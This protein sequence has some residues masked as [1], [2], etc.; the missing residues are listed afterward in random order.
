MQDKR[1]GRG[2]NPH[3]QGPEHFAG[4]S[5]G[6]EKGGAYD[7]EMLIRSGRSHGDVCQG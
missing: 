2:D 7:Y 3:L 1:G 4:V 6:E 5:V